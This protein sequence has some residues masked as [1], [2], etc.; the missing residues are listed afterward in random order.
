MRD[1]VR[2]LAAFGTVIIAFPLALSIS[3]RSVTGGNYLAWQLFRRPNHG[4]SFYPSNVPDA[5]GYLLL[6]AAIAGL[7][8]L[9]RERSWRETLL[10]SWIAVPVIFFQ[11]WPVKGFQ[12][13]L[14][15]APVIAIL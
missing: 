4:C 7:F 14:P 13:L 11:V 6:A 1:V 3:L 2:S 9:R 15:I 12:Y 10:L 8:L 5:L